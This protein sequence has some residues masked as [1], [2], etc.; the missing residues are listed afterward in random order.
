[1]GN[2]FHEMSDTEI[3]KQLAENRSELRELRFTFAEARSLPDPD[4]VRRTRRDIARM[5]TVQRERE[6]GLTEVKEKTNRKKSKGDST[7][8]APVKNKQSKTKKGAEATKK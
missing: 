8:S 2:I 1:M 7:A 3:T 4:K 6:M 5:L